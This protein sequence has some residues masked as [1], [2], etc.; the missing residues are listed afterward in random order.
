MVMFKVTGEA[1]KERADDRWCVHDIEW[2]LHVIGDDKRGS[3]DRAVVARGWT[4]AG[5]RI[6]I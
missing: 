6:N 1:C 4:R 3:P 2:V 5:P